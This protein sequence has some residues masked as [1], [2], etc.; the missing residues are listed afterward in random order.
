MA[1]E[2]KDNTVQ[3][4]RVGR[5]SEN[6]DLEAAKSGCFFSRALTLTAHDKPSELMQY[7]H[8]STHTSSTLTHL[9]TQAV[10]SRIY[11]HTHT[12]LHL[13]ETGTCQ[14]PMAHSMNRCTL[15]QGPS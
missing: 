4:A 7:S 9:H 3:A 8:A 1:L 13:Y 2:S 11:T 15:T 12:R 10:L 6:G 14:S 5:C